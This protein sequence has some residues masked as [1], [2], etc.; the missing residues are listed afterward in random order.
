MGQEVKIKVAK[1]VLPSVGDYLFGAL[2]SW[3][4]YQSQESA[5][6]HLVTN[7]FAWTERG[8]RRKAE[9]AAKR[10]LEPFVVEYE[11]NP[12]GLL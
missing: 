9:K 8:A 6:V 5:Y 3:S 10:L 12:A 2:W 1:S 7:G 11:Y 4:L